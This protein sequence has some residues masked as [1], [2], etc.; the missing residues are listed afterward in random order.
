M[1]GKMTILDRLAREGKI[2][3][4]PARDLR[5]RGEFFDP[6]NYTTQQRI[7][8]EGAP[9]LAYMAIPQNGVGRDIKLTPEREVY[10]RGLQA[11]R[12]KEL[13]DVD[14]RYNA[15]ESM[16][17]D[18]QSDF[19][20]S[21]NDAYEAMKG[22]LF[23]GRDI[24]PLL[25]EGFDPRDDLNM[26]S[27][28]DVNLRDYWPSYT[29][30]PDEY[31]SEAEDYVDQMK[32]FTRRA[33]Y[34]ES[35]EHWMELQSQSPRYRNYQRAMEQRAA[36]KAVGRDLSRRY[37]TAVRN[38]VRRGLSPEEADAYVRQYFGGH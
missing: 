7:S 33:A 28:E 3:S 13:A 32:G 25:N 17:A 16:L 8:M 29:R 38:L 37:A 36:N 6:L 4:P 20:E 2:K 34:L 15:T 14:D 19:E 18:L 12:N 21:Y 1:A 27:L 35:P 23:D 24:A 31:A 22:D 11:I 26:G 30:S 9:E 5:F 10:Q